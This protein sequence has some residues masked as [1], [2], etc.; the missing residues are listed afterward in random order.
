MNE[1]WKDLKEYPNHQAST[2]GQIRNKKTGHILKPSVDKDGYLKVSIGSKDNVSVHRLICKMF[3]GIPNDKKSQVNHIDC[4]RQNNN[5]SN[6]EWCTPKENI[7][8]GVDHGNINPMMGLKKAIDV[9]KRSVKITETNQ[10]FETVKDCAGFLGVPSTNVS[11]CLT[12]SRKGQRIHGY[13]IEY[14]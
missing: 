9:N 1:R 3:N 11:R 8:W 7:K 2:N 5:I 6:L 4:N 12:G 10:I 13:H 14:V